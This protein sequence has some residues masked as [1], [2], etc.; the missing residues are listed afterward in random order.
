MRW[1]DS[2]V[3]KAL[4][5]Y[6]VDLGS[7]LSSPYGCLTSDYQKSV[8]NLATFKRKIFF[9]NWQGK[10]FLFVLILGNNK[11]S[12]DLIPGSEFQDHSWR[13]SGESPEGDQM[14]CQGLDLS[15]PHA[16]QRPFLMDYNSG[17]VNK[18]CLNP[19]QNE[20][21]AN[22]LKDIGKKKGL[23]SAYIIIF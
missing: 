16:R 3:G 20:V 7:I 15:Q 10:G 5:L 8:M 21:C 9:S 11:Q 12:S 14:V 22:L 6:T 18:I 1:D 17:P 2:T 23:T 13:W 4:V 19:K